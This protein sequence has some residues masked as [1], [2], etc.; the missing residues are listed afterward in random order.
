MHQF[1][2]CMLKL[3]VSNGGERGGEVQTCSA[4]LTFM[5]DMN[6]ASAPVPD[7]LVTASVTGNM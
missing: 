5:T 2:T 6:V 4:D 3:Q 1:R 7:T